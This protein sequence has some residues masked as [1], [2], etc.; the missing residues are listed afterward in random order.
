[1]NI[2]KPLNVAMIFDD[3]MLGGWTTIASAIPVFDRKKINPSVFCLFGKGYYAD[4]L[5]KKGFE[6][7]FLN[8]NKFNLPFKILYLAWLLRKNNIDIVHTHLIL[9]HVIGQ[10]AAV[11][12]GVPARIMH[13]HAA[14]KDTG[15]L[16]GLWSKWVI[17]RTGMIIPVSRAVETSFRLTYPSFKGRSHLVYNGIDVCEFRRR[18]SMSGLKRSGLGIG[19]DDFCA[20]TVANFKSEKGHGYLID[21]ASILNDGNIRFLLIGAGAGKEAVVEEVKKRGLEKQ[22]VFLGGREDVPELLS[23]ADIMVLPSIEEGFGICLLEAFAV[24]IPVLATDVCGIT[25][26]VENGKDALL[27]PPSN[28]QELAEGIRKLKEN[29]SLC[30]VLSENAK[31][32]AMDFDIGKVVQ[33]YTEAYYQ[34]PG[35]RKE[36]HH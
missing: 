3:L 15:G 8:I 23:L 19:P 2:Y 14:Q 4:C 6:V 24:G 28:P 30:R 25:E 34:M 5:E 29:P 1:V 33:Y 9:S 32:K 13:V 31:E 27:V 18:F 21:A 10:S 22:F 17:R 7:H 36:V 35:K 12:A 16:L 20:V 11:I 26:I